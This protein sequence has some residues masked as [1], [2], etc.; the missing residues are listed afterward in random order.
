[1][2]FRRTDTKMYMT[3]Q[4]ILNAFRE[5]FQ[6]DVKVMPGA[7]LDETEQ[8]LLT[9]L[10]EFEREMKDYIIKNHDYGAIP[11]TDEYANG[12]NDSRKRSFEHLKSILSQLEKEKRT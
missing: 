7:P 11:E 2:A 10:T 9:T 8:W 6:P 5:Y 4:D 12:W 1:M 3:K